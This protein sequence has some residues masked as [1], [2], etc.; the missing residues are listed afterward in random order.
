MTT[1]SRADDQPSSSFPNYPPPANHTF[2]A[3]AGTQ[4]TEVRH[5]S[6][7]ARFG[8]GSL[9]PIPY[10][11]YIFP[12]FFYPHSGPSQNISIPYINSMPSYD[13]SFAQY[14][15]NLDEIRP[16]AIM[17]MDGMSTRPSCS[18][19]IPSLGDP[20]P[21]DE[22]FDLDEILCLREQ[23]PLKL[24]LP[25]GQPSALPTQPSR[26][27]VRNSK[28]LQFHPYT[29]VSNSKLRGFDATTKN[30]LDNVT[31]AEPSQPLRSIGPL[32][33]DDDNKTH[34]KI[35]KIAERSLIKDAVNLTPFL[36]EQEKK[37]GAQDAL[38]KA[39]SHFDSGNIWAS[40]NTLTFYRSLNPMPSAHI[41]AT[42]KK[43]ARAL[44]QRG[45]HLRPS[46]WLR[47]SE[48]Q[49][50]IQKTKNLIASSPPAFIFGKDEH[51]RSWAF[52]NDVVLDVVLYTM[53]ELNYLPY[54]TDPTLKSMFC[55]AS[56]AVKC[57]LQ[58]RLTNEEIKFGVTEF[59]PVY[60]RFSD[61]FDENIVPV[62]ELLARWKE[63]ALLVLD[64]LRDICQP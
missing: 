11:P 39:T 50:Q 33:Y 5:S 28:S 2:V 51:G 41:M 15:D 35:F 60:D 32:V 17:S 26:P 42:S 61:Y 48:R 64:T 56:T 34:R 6:N 10:N 54:V 43:I 57:A 7:T 58:E 8:E 22:P 20:V 36:S 47:I 59:K 21:L 53:V 55:T 31:E 40:K 46:V 49:Y 1:G 12:N 63:Y 52:E 19:D 3:A 23:P 9:T 24:P 27:R 30:S 45:Y 37:Q 38:A 25:V 4:P 14:F 16:Q 62:P 18:E 44:V 13:P 29:G